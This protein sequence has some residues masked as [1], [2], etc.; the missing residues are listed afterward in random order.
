MILGPTIPNTLDSLRDLVVQHIGLVERGLRVL[1]EDL[2]LGHNAPVDVAA[3]DAGGSPVLIFLAAPDTSAGLPSRVVRAQCWLQ[4]NAEWLGQELGDPGLR[5][6]APVRYVVVGLEILADTIDQLD[7][8]EIDGLAVLEFCSLTVGGRMRLGITRMMEREATPALGARQGAAA[9]AFC[10]PTGIVQPDHR[11]VA[12]RFLDLARRADPRITSSSDRFSSKLFLG[13]QLIAELGM[14]GGDLRVTFPALD[15]GMPE[16]VVGL[17][18]QLCLAAIDQLLRRIL[19][20]EPGVPAVRF[21]EQDS[22]GSPDRD[23]VTAVRLRPNPMVGGQDSREESLVDRLLDQSIEN[24]R[25][26]LEP[27]RRSVAASQLSRE[28]FSALGDGAP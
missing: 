2:V 23:P 14:S 1:A 20:I 24:S 4:R 27:I 11:A 10:A 19:S 9:A 22:H 13:S 6:E 8:L 15:A 21:A 5:M 7:R 17:T 12:A 28:E 25:F 3:C 18:Q 26:S 16:E